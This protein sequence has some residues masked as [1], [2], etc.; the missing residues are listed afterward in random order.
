MSSRDYP[1]HEPQRVNV[2]AE[3]DRL[4]IVDVARMFGL[5]VAADGIACP[6]CRV[7]TRDGHRA[8]ARLSDGRWHCKRCGQGGGRLRLVAFVLLGRAAVSREDWRD[9]AVKIAERAAPVPAVPSAPA[10]PPPRVPLRE[11][12]RV[13]DDCGRADVDP[14]VAR[15]LRGRGLDPALAARADLVRARGSVRVPWLP[16]DVSDRRA[17]LAAWDV[18][19]EVASLR[20][21]RTVV[22]RG[23]RP[24]PSAVPKGHRSAPKAMP[25][26]GRADPRTGGASYAI[27]GTL[28]ANPAAVALLRGVEFA[29]WNGAV[30]I[31]EGEPDWLTVAL[32]RVPK[33]AVFGIWQGSWT[34]AIANRI[35]VGAE[36]VIA[37][38]HDAAGEK[39]AAAIA[40]TLRGCTV[41]RTTPGP[42]ENDR[43]MA[44]IRERR[45]AK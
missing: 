38:H 35:P 25:P 44:A 12:A 39:Y 34:Q 16:G 14:C 29:S 4:P 26:S 8:A 15:W 20:F 24:Y 37:V 2:L 28:L 33:A 13:W 32:H 22:P 42:D 40:T 41:E 30:W 43:W 10:P 23:S 36:V 19:G 31:C 45:A 27:G 21:R 3:I 18:S 1:A 7:E 5:A 17:V 9:L 6:A 11:V